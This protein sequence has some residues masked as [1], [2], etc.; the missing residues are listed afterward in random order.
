MT[1]PETN[2]RKATIKNLDKAG[3]QPVVCMFNP[4]EY[5]FSKTNNWDDGKTPAQDINQM[6]F[7]GG[8]SATLTMQFFFDTYAERTDVREKYT[9]AFW[10]LM[11]I[12]SSKKDKKNEFGRPPR[13]L[14]QWGRTWSFEAVITSMKQQ[15]TLFLDTGIPVRAT[16]DVTFKQVTDPGQLRAQNPT[17]GGEGGE[18]VWRVEAGD[19]LAWIAYREYGDATKWRLIAEANRLTRVRELTPGSVLVI[20]NE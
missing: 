14:F 1:R 7:T 5:T 8:D 20:P 17:S 10:E 3:S 15:F 16:L 13:V 6:T 18:R 19:T 9:D 4:K 2:L 12:D 11:K